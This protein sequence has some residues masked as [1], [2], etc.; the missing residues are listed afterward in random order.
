MPPWRR[1]PLIG[2]L[3]AA[4]DRTTPADSPVTLSAQVSPS[5]EMEGKLPLKFRAGMG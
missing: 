1:L 4:I 5:K 3:L 2:R